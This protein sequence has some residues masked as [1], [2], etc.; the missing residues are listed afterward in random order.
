MS[1]GIVNF[2]FIEKVSV[3]SFLVAGHLPVF[4]FPSYSSYESAV[5]LINSDRVIP[6]ESVILSKVSISPFL[7]NGCV[8]F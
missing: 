4:L 5:P 2:R 6:A 1:L 3:L 8:E 7:L